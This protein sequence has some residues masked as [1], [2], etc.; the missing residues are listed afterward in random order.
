MQTQALTNLTPDTI[1]YWAQNKTL[2]DAARRQ[3]EQLRDLKNQFA[4]VNTEVTANDNDVAA[5]TRDEDR[6]R[7][8]IAS[9]NSVSGQQQQVQTY[10]RQLSDLETKI[11]ALRDRHAELEK[12]K[13]ALQAQINTT[14]EKMSF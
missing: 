11:T 10:A 9:L 14:I 7:Q 3:L 2:S 8:N 1:V 12:Q 4:S 6:A 13:N 5:V